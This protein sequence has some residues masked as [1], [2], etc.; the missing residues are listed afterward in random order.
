MLAAFVFIQQ[1]EHSAGL[2]VLLFDLLDQLV[3]LEFFL[4]NP[5]A[6]YIAADIA[7]VG[8]VTAESALKH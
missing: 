1:K 3:D 4:H 8:Q 6:D 2:T 7:A 5:Q